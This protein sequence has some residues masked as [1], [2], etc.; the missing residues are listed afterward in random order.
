[1]KLVFNSPARSK[2]SSASPPL[3]EP[4][5][6]IAITFPFSPLT[7]LAF[8]SPNAKLIEVEVCPKIK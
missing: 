1:M 6:M 2:P 7:S 4:S 5:P 3:R 8:A